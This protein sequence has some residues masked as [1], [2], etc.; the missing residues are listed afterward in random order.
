MPS[1]L[2]GAG[3]QATIAVAGLAVAALGA[4]WF[5]GVWPRLR[6]ALLTATVI[7]LLSPFA[8]VALFAPHTTL[9]SDGAPRQRPVVVL[10]LDEFSAGSAQ[11][12]LTEIDARGFDVKSWKFRSIGVNTIDAI[13]AIFTGRPLMDARPCTTSAICG[14]TRVVDF[15]RMHAGRDDVDV[16]G[17]YHPYCAIGGLRYCLN[18]DSDRELPLVRTFLCSLPLRLFMDRYL[19]CPKR[20]YASPGARSATDMESKLFA[21]PFWSKGG[22]LFA[23]LILPHPPSFSGEER[24]AEAYA[25]NIARANKLVFD[26]LDRLDHGPHGGDYALVITSDHPLRSSTWCKV[27]P[28]SRYDCD[29]P[30]AMEDANVPFIVVNRGTQATYPE[31]R[32]NA[33]LLAVAA[34]LSGPGR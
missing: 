3:M 6:L 20:G 8:L 11:D 12:L 24:L 27:E 33:D 4:R 32:S 23:H 1:E 10:L 9:F 31:P 19:E 26:V 29:L 2:L 28:F 34:G 30:A 21:A 14:R 7:A 22:L 17:I 25:A 18:Q 16:V 13:P 15:G 5:A